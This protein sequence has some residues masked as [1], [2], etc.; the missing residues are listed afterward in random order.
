MS[1]DFS[2]LEK[3][4]RKG[5][6][7]KA[8]AVLIHAEQG[9]GKTTFGDGCPDPVFIAGEEVEQVD[10]AQ[11]LPKVKTWGDFLEQ[12]EYLRDVKKDYKT[13]V[14]DTLD[15][16]EQVLHKHIVDEDKYD[17]MATACGGFGKSYDKAAE[18][19]LS[20]RDEFLVP[21]RESGKNIV[22]LCHSLRYKVEDPILQVAYERFEPKIHAKRNGL[23]S[24]AVFCDWVSIIG[25]GTTEKT[26]SRSADGRDLL[27][28]DSN[29]RVL[30]CIPKPNVMAKNRFKMPE[31]I[32]LKWKYVERCVDKFYSSEKNP[33]AEELLEELR[34]L[35]SQIKSKSVKDTAIK[36]VKSAGT[37]MEKLTKAKDFIA[38]YL[39]TEE[40]R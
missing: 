9:E 11:V 13:L 34:G 24:R 38:N 17:T 30:Y 31:K 8:L 5:R 6:V 18:M 40:E 19:F 1:K 39:N 36:N 4:I 32:P 27:F 10:N 23:G 22:I 12:L 37:D 16:I 25:W 7:R 2:K 14:I 33:E 28:S 29:K 15:S 21:I 3:S 35:V 26:K 20:V